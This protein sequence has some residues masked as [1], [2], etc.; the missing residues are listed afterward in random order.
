MVSGALMSSPPQCPEAAFIAAGS[1]GGTRWTLS[2]GRHVRI[3]GLGM[4]PPSSP[5]SDEILTKLEADLD[6]GGVTGA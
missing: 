3:P 4:T 6:A 1:G 2:S 5:S